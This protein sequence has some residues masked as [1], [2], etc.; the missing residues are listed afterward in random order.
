MNLKNTHINILWQGCQPDHVV[1]NLVIE[2]KLIYQNT[3]LQPHLTS[4]LEELLSKLFPEALTLLV[5]PMG[6]GRSG[7]GVLKVRPF[8]PDRGGGCKVVVK[9][10]DIT[11][12]EQ[13]YANFMKYVQGF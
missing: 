13:E 3:P 6:R 10:G 11:L 4:E 5:E 1:L 8:Y 2:G 12:I 9:F 7:I